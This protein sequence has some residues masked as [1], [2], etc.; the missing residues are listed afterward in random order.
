M[1]YV[2]NRYL[3]PWL[4]LYILDISGQ[5]A[6]ELHREI[7]GNH[8]AIIANI[9][10]KYLRSFL[11]LAKIVYKDCLDFSNWENPVRTLP[12]RAPGTRSS[13]EPGSCPRI[14]S[15]PG[16]TQCWPC[17]RRPGIQPRS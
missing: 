4:D 16:S 17:D 13:G 10:L 6:L 7:T 3:K 5:M 11:N 2:L 15:V 1:R 14:S 9:S 12:K 8:G